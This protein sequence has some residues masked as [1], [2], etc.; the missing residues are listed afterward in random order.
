MER[1]QE[2]F[3]KNRVI[4]TN[5]IGNHC[6]VLLVIDNESIRNHVADVLMS[7]GHKVQIS[8]NSKGLLPH[9]NLGHQHPKNSFNIIVSDDMMKANGQ[10]IYL[11]MLLLQKE[12]CLK[13]Y[14]K[15]FDKKR[16]LPVAV[17][18]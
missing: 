13:S 5:E 3:Q 12:R 16:T 10:H 18:I 11:Q 7:K 1:M 6:N 14:L 8:Q 4:A 2:N 15:V 17:V 9:L